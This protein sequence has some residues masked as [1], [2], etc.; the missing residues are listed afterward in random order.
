MRNVEFW[1]QDASARTWVAF[2]DFFLLTSTYLSSDEELA[3]AV[4]AAVKNGYRMIDAASFYISSHA[5]L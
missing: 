4:V 1:L 3:A 2:E 5:L